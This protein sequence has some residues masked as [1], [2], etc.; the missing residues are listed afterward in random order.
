M[1]DRKNKNSSWRPGSARTRRESLQR[2][3]INPFRIS[4][5]FPQFLPRYASTVG[6]SIL[7]AFRSKVRHAET[8]YKHTHSAL[9]WLSFKSLRNRYHNLILIPHC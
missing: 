1:V 3:P 5:F 2:H 4:R 9:S 7:H 8:I 6:L